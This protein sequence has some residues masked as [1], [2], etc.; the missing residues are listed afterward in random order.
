MMIAAMI[1]RVDKYSPS[2][3]CKDFH[4]KCIS[5]AVAVYKYD[6]ANV[7]RKTKDWWYGWENVKQE[8][9]GGIDQMSQ[10]VW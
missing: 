10:L 5:K 9:Q 7:E 8:R 2:N 1:Q 3:F 6:A 4:C